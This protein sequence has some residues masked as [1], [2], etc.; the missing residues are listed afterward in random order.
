MSLPL[1]NRAVKAHVRES[2]AK[3]TGDIYALSGDIE[4][5]V[6]QYCGGFYACVKARSVRGAK[7]VFERLMHE[8]LPNH[9]VFAFHVVHYKSVKLV[10]GSF[11]F[12]MTH[13]RKPRKVI[14]A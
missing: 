9:C 14:S 12:G 1:I 4:S 10:P 2:R 6:P 7:S 3:S 11:V 13:L 8:E 5:A